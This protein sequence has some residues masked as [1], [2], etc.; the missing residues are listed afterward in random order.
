MSEYEKQT[1]EADTKIPVANTIQKKPPHAKPKISYGS[2]SRSQSD[3][4]LSHETRS[5]PKVRL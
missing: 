4:K 3:Q 1:K 5:D 2:A